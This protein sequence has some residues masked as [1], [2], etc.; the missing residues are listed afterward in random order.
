EQHERF[1][2][3]LYSSIAVCALVHESG[4]DARNQRS[5]VKADGDIP[6]CKEDDLPRV[7]GMSKD[8]AETMWGQ[9]RHSGCYGSVSGQ[10]ANR[11]RRGA[12]RL[13][14]EIWWRVAKHR[15]A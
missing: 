9:R 5:H 15:I 12:R 6:P 11:I 4:P 13:R 1:R 8:N 7:Q 14:Y 2:L 10:T 3:R